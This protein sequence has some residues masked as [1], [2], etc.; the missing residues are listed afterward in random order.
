MVPPRM[1][2]LPWVS[3]KAGE[4]KINPWV[5]PLEL[6]DWTMPT[7]IEFFHIAPLSYQQP[8][9]GC[10]LMFSCVLP[11]WEGRHG[12]YVKMPVS[13]WCSASAFFIKHSPG[14]NCWSDSKVPKKLI[15]QFYDGGRIDTQGWWGNSGLTWFFMYILNIWNAL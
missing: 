3:S 4:T 5:G 13:P 7:T 14:C 1:L 2:L 15:W 6:L 12:E 10:G 9:M 8:T 11:N